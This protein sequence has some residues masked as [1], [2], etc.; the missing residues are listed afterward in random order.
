MKF[1]DNIFKALTY[2]DWE[3]A[4]NCLIKNLIIKIEDLIKDKELRTKFNDL[5]NLIISLR[6]NCV[7]ATKHWD[8]LVQKECIDLYNNIYNLEIINLSKNT[9]TNYIKKYANQ[10]KERN[11]VQGKSGTYHGYGNNPCEIIINILNFEEIP[12]VDFN[13]VNKELLPI[14]LKVLYNKKQTTSEKTSCFKLLMNLESKSKV[15]N[16]SYDWT[17]F[18]NRIFKYKN[19]VL[20]ANEVIG[21]TIYSSSTLKLYAFFYEIIN[22]Y[23]NEQEALSIFA[24]L[25]NLDR[26]D[27]IQFIEGIHDYIKYYKTINDMEIPYLTYILQIIFSKSYNEYFVIRLKV[28][29]CLGALCNTDFKDIIL[30]RL[31]EMIEDSDYR[32]RLKVL[33]Q[34][35]KIKN[36]D[37]YSI[38]NILQKAKVDNNFIIKSWLK[39]NSY[40]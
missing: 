17:S 34:L 8:D 24:E 12:E 1:F 3:K 27:N 19:K 11:K 33:L 18:S 39:E 36:I 26:L 23:K 5:I 6:K 10:I 7:E 37:D 15:N 2:L 14:L 28:V 13:D 40:I 4:D 29:A 9:A 25:S 20:S 31:S 32:V 38:N 16:F 21:F 22:G 35:D 30:F